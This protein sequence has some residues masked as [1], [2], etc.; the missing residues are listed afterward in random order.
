MPNQSNCEHPAILLYRR[1]SE[2]GGKAKDQVPAFVQKTNAAY[3]NPAYQV[4]F[5]LIQSRQQAARSAH[6]NAGWAVQVIQAKVNWR[7]AV[8]L[9]YGRLWDVGFQLHPLYGIPYLPASGIKGALRRWADET[10]T[11]N[12]DTIFGTTSQQSQVVLFDAFPTTKG[13]LLQADVL[14]KH[15][16]NYYE[17]KPNEIKPPTDYDTPEPV[18]FL[19]IKRG[20]RFSI[21]FAIR[22]G[23]DPAVSPIAV[24]NLILSCL[25]IAGLGAKTAKG[26]GRM[27]PDA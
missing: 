15:H 21:S 10:E 12:I 16:K 9:S 3:A 5:P 23:A 8:G 27:Q 13:Q 11:A 20:V 14:N 24:K 2:F 26:Y 18:N 25:R 17:A 6:Q 4:L 1:L 7:L 22:P 19:T